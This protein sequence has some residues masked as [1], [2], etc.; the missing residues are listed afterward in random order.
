MGGPVRRKGLQRSFEV[1]IGR[2]VENE[3]DGVVVAAR[4]R[5]LEKIARRVQRVEAM[6]EEL[7]SVFFFD[8]RERAVRERFRDPVERGVKIVI[9]LPEGGVCGRHLRMELLSLRPLVVAEVLVFEIV[10]KNK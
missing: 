1:G 6:P 4:V 2:L 3:I 7:L 8:A 10:V 5:C 9:R